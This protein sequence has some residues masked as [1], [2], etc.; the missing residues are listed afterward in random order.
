MASCETWVIPDPFRE[1][2]SLSIC[3]SWKTGGERRTVGTIRSPGFA[4]SATSGNQFGNLK[5]NTRYVAVLYSGTASASSPLIRRCFKTRGE[6]AVNPVVHP[7]GGGSRSGC[8][9]VGTTRQDVTE[10]FCDGQQP[11][12][13]R[14]GPG[15]GVP[16]HQLSHA[17]LHETEAASGPPFL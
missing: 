11:D 12:H 8:F 6:W 13:Y 15:Y 14:R 1:A 3:R 9:A 2:E 16:G 10:C 4:I 5:N 17:G 7:S